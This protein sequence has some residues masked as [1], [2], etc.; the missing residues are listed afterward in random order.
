MALRTE[1]SISALSALS[2]LPDTRAA[3]REVAG[4]LQASSPLRADVLFVFASFHHRAL[5]RDSLDF[6]RRELHPA[7]LL[8][9]TVESV[10]SGTREVEHTPGLSVLALSAPGIVA[11]PFWFDLEDGPPAVWSEGFIRQRITL[12]PD[13]GAGGGALAH[14]GTILFADPHSIHPGEA[15]AAIDAAAGPE[16]ARIFG[17]VA[18]GASHAGLNVLAVDRHVSHGGLVG[19]SI[20]GDID[21]ASL[22]SQGCRPIG[23]EFVVTAAR[24]NEILALNGHR[25]IDAVRDMVESLAES[26]RSCIGQGLLVGLALDCTKQRRGRGDYL[27]RPVLAVESAS[28]SISL[29]DRVHSGQTVCFHIR[30]QQTAEDDLAMMLDREQLRDPVKAA[31]LFT[32][33]VR[34]TRFFSTPDHDASTVSRRLH[35]SALA[36]FQCAGEIGP[37]GK[38]SFVHTQTASVVLFRNARAGF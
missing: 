38:R 2:E 1:R 30:D 33:N 26:D 34:G 14:R 37:Q 6:L 10:V 3:A 17:G 16:G 13:E 23:G 22:V 9:T 15:C 4:M 31:L 36:G 21:I 35:T 27:V 29:G 7:H 19:L 28:G 18:S 12:P 32:C 24:G 11:R 5:L 25:A 20:F 8:A